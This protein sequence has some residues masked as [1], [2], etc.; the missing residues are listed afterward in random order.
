MRGSG[1]GSSRWYCFSGDIPEHWRS[2]AR[3]R[4]VTL[5]Q[6]GGDAGIADAG[7]DGRYKIET[8]RWR[9]T[10]LVSGVLVRARVI[11]A[12]TGETIELGRE[13]WAE[14]IVSVLTLADQGLLP[15]QSSGASPFSRFQLSSIHRGWH[16]LVRAEGAAEHEYI[17]RTKHPAFGKRIADALNQD[18]PRMLADASGPV[19]AYGF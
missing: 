15:P 17:G 2:S 13:S 10:F 14:R 1:T 6:Q 7:F 4:L 18:D 9:W 8:V 16:R 12:E 19:R 5:T 11:D 3:L